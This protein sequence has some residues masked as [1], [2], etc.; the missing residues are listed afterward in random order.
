LG[1]Y[2]GESGAW[3]T[4][5]ANEAAQRVRIE[6]VGSEGFLERLVDRISSVCAAVA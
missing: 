5:V 3:I 6:A 2:L 1:F 4:S